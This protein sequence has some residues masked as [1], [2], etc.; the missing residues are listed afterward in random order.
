MVREKGN[1]RMTKKRDSERGI[2][3][4]D[5][6]LTAHLENSGDECFLSIQFE[7]KF[8]YVPRSRTL[9]GNYL[10]TPY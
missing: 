7:H 3:S 6:N 2:Y 1:N 5:N 9:L 4:R 10:G 8:T